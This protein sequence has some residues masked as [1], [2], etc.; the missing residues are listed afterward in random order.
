MTL[1]RKLSPL[2]PV[3]VPVLVLALG[4]GAALAPGAAGAE[5][6]DGPYA[7]IG[8]GLGIL[9]SE[10]STIAGPFDRSDKD[11]VVTGLAGFRKP[12]GASGLVVGVEGDAGVNVDNGDG[13]YGVSGIAGF[14]LGGNSLLFGRAGYGWRDGLPRDTGKGLVLGAGF[15]TLLA[16]R[17]N[18]RLDYR[19]QDLGG[20]DFPDNTVDFAGHEVTAG[21]VFGF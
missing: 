6:F 8:A 16:D 9:E 7:G 17:V 13:R 12:V 11:A 2:A 20:L 21:V 15:E 1:S 5:A 19:H 18:L 14:R 4:A 3:L 10:G